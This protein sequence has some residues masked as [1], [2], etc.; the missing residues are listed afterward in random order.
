M[1]RCQSGG[2][3][4]I[5]KKSQSEPTPETQHSQHGKCSWAKFSHLGSSRSQALA[6]ERISAKLRFAVL[7]VDQE[8]SFTE[9]G[10]TVDSFGTAGEAGASGTG[11]P[12]PEFGNELKKRFGISNLPGESTFDSFVA[13]VEAGASRIGVPKPKL[14]NELKHISAKLRFAVLDVV[15]D[16]SFTDCGPTVDSF[17]AAGEAGAS[18]IGV[19][20]PE[21]GNELKTGV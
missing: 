1:L 13:A 16:L 11:V 6:W 14:G 9:C 17:G 5:C 20:K 19:P 18:G 7:D 21:L 15:Q 2:F 8:L 3:Y 10:P 4:E 12:K